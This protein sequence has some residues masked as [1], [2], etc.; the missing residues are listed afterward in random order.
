[1]VGAL[2]MISVTVNKLE[3]PAHPSL[4]YT[5]TEYAPVAETSVVDVV[6]PLLH[7]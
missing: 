3:N 4:S 5:N 2:P 1:M 6:A 7:S